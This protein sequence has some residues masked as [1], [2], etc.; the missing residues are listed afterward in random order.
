MMVLIPLLYGF[1]VTEAETKLV[2]GMILA[3]L[4]TTYG[5]ISFSAEWEKR[6]W[7]IDFKR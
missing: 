6:G 2:I 4:G 3:G 5:V 7:G 1:I